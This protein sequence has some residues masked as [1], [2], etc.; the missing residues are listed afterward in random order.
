MK[1]GNLALPGMH[2]KTY[3]VG[4]VWEARIVGVGTST[5]D[6]QYTNAA[7]H[8]A[9]GCTSRLKDPKDWEFTGEFDPEE[10]K[11]R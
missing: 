10:S 8:M 7:N 4:N 5:I 9:K 2:I 6:V 3:Y 1:D 11:P